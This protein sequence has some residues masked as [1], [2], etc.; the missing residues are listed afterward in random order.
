M[1]K[2][3]VYFINGLTSLYILKQYSKTSILI[4]MRLKYLIETKAAL[5]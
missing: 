5:G 2:S 3:K 4:L 1:V